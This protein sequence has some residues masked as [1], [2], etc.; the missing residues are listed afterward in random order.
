MGVLSSPP[1]PWTEQNRVTVIP[2]RTYYAAG[3]GEP[4][5]PGHAVIDRIKSKL[6]QSQAEKGH[7]QQVARG[8]EFLSAHPLPAHGDPERS[9]AFVK[10]VKR[11]PEADIEAV[12]QA[13]ATKLDSIHSSYFPWDHPA[14]SNAAFLGWFRRAA[15]YYIWERDVKLACK[16]FGRM[17]PSEW[18]EVHQIVE[19]AAKRC[20]AGDRSGE[21]ALLMLR[22]AASPSGVIALES[23]QEPFVQQTDVGAAFVFAGTYR[24][25][26]PTDK[27]QKGAAKVATECE[28]GA[29]IGAC[30]AMLDHIGRMPEAVS[31]VTGNH[32][33]GL[34][35]L[36][37]AFPADES[38]PVLQRALVV[39]ADKIPGVGPRSLKGFLGAVWG[40]EALGT[41]PALAA[42]ATARPRVKTTAPSTALE[43][44]LTRAAEAQG[45]TLEELEE[46]V[47]P[48]FPFDENGVLRVGMGPDSAAIT[49]DDRARVQIEW[50]SGSKIVAS[51]T[52]AMKSAFAEEVALVRR[53]KKDLET[54]ISAQRR[55]LDGMLISEREI[56]YREWVERYLDRPLLQP[57]ARRLIWR[58]QHQGQV[59]TLMPRPE[60]LLN[61]HGERLAEMP[62]E[63]R[64]K[65][66]HPLDSHESEI[67][68]WRDF[69]HQHEITQPFKQAYR[70]HYVLT[71]AEE[72]TRIY[73]NRFAAQILVQAQFLALLRE[74][75]WRADVLGYF[76]NMPQPPRRR[77][78][79]WNLAAEFLVEVAGEDMNDL[80]L[81]SYVST[82]QLRFLRG[83]DALPLA[84]IPAVVFSEICRDV[85]LFVGVTSIGN[86][87]TWLDQGARDV[88]APTAWHALSFGDLGPLAQT[89][90]DVLRRLLPRLAIGKVSTLEGNFLRVQGKR[91][92]YRI[93]L[94]SGNILI[95]PHDRYLCI[96]PASGKGDGNIYLPFEGDRTLAIILSKAMMLMNDDTITDPTI[97]AQIS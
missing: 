19:A 56:T 89:R 22:Q 74:R 12:A 20:H 60:G 72:V 78:S 91:H 84:E 86:D 94:G 8:Q 28:A 55:R 2:L 33:R 76:D 41:F 80:G 42:M 88:A 32:L 93:H 36:L 6:N 54:A 57:L 79:E 34:I 26:S 13:L 64:V 68:A 69:L 11:L 75:G 37:T 30:S 65:I 66:W 4:P 49:L 24:G 70:E 40:L 87:P 15:R 90:Q 45:L 97:L 82:D 21:Y 27:F 17:A 9:R 23:W 1:S 7:V 46:R 52:A 95:A 92:A 25:A 35:T 43:A 83:Q 3:E 53:T 58:M 48:E 71:P 18:D 85:D 96:V 44:A 31:T 67:A 50:R 10:M 77:L 39:L 29:Y 47:V 81:A 62:D 59:V 38:I 51:P 63:T 14:V 5:L 61:A 16:R 73:S